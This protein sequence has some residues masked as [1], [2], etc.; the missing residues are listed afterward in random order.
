MI[1][2]K[3]TQNKMKTYNQFSVESHSARENLHE[4]A[5]TG[6]A[7]GAGLFKL[8]KLGLGAYSAYEAGK[9]LKKGD[10]TGAA[11]NT[12]QAVNPLGKF[13]IAAGLTDM[14]RPRGDDKKNDTAPAAPS[15]N[16]VA[17]KKSQTTQP[18]TQP[19][20]KP[21]SI[22]LA[23]KGGVQ[24]KLDKATGK[25]TKGDWT[26]E[27][28]DRYKKVAAQKAAPKP[29]PAASKPAPVVRSNNINLPSG[30]ASGAAAK[31][32]VKKST[33]VGE[34]IKTKVNP[35]SSLQVTQKRS[36]DATDKI[37]KA[38]DIN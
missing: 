9:S 24:G 13:G 12:V 37:K 36:K 8:A 6:A 38:L 29:A 34:T 20:T 32:A 18:T 1:N 27:E 7:L 31:S 15:N 25:W 11:L 16:T 2:N 26:K 17:N 10:Y 28:S 33:P 19:K 35:D 23:R 14:V 30:V 4:I 22:V 3:K 5:F 21:S